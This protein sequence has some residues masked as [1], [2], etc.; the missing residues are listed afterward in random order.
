MLFP[1]A[2]IDKIHLI[3]IAL[4]QLPLWCLTQCPTHNDIWY[5]GYTSQVMAFQHFLIWIDIVTCKLCYQID[6]VER[7]YKVAKKGNTQVKYSTWVNFT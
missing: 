3:K 5:L 2:N 4:M 7:K 1:I 6:V